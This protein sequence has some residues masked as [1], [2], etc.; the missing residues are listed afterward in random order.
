MK[1]INSHIPVKEY[2]YYI[3]TNNNIKLKYIRLHFYV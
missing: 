1:Q 3:E 2:Q